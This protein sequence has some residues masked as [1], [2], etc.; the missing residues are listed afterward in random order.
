MQ[1]ASHKPKLTVVSSFHYLRLVYRSALFLAFLGMYLSFR[2]KGGAEISTVLES[3]PMILSL[4]W[5][6]FMVEMVLRFFPSR[7]CAGGSDLDRL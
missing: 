5:A 2:L 1:K 4:I 7:G 3:R 6:V